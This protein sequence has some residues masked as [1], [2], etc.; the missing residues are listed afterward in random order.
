MSF[1]SAVLLILAAIG[2]FLSVYFLAARGLWQRAQHSQSGIDSA[3]RTIASLH[4]VEAAF[5][6]HEAALRGCLLMRSTTCEQDLSTAATRIGGELSGLRALM[7]DG[8]A[9]AEIDRLDTLARS[10]AA[11]AIGAT[12]PFGG[13]AGTPALSEA[14]VLRI[15]SEIRA[16]VMRIDAMAG[17]ILSDRKVLYN[18]RI[19]ACYLFSVGAFAALCLMVGLMLYRIYQV[20][21]RNTTVEDI[22]R[23]SEARYRMLVEGSDMVLIV[24][25]RAG[26]VTFASDNIERLTGYGC[27]ELVG[28]NALR[29]MPKLAGELPADTPP[30]GRD[31]EYLFTTRDGKERWAAY[32]VTEQTGP[33]GH[34]EYHIIAWDID[35]EKR[36]RLAM[37]GLEEARRQ[38]Q[39]LL[40]DVIDH[41]PNMVY[42]KDLQGNYAVVNRPLRELFGKLTPQ[43]IGRKLGEFFGPEAEDGR[44]RRTDEHVVNDKQPV[45]FEEEYEFYGE[46]RYFWEVKFPVFDEG[47]AVRYVGGIASDITERKQEEL[48]LREA[49]GE[50]EKARTA[51]EAF[52][53]SMSHEIRT[54]MNGVVGMANLMLGTRLSG[55]QREFTETILE[56]ARNLLALIN[57][58]LDFSK[59]ESGR[60]EFEHTPFRVRHAL[61]RAIHPLR[62]KAEEKGLHLDLELVE[63]LPEVLIGDALRLQQ[64]VI[65]LVG[66]AIKFTSEGAVTVR[67]GGALAGTGAVMLR[68]DVQDTGIGIPKDKLGFV[69]ESFAQQHAAMS[70]SYGGTGLGLAIVRQLAE[71]Q[72][73]TVEVESVLGKGSTF[74]VSIPF[75]VSTE[76]AALP[77]QES[78]VSSTAPEH[79]LEGLCIL[80]AED[81]P[82][83]QKVV[84]NTLAR[85]GAEV[86]I[87]GSGTQAVSALRQQSFDVVLM[88]I[89][90]P[91]MDGYAATRAIREELNSGIPIIA[92][93]ADALK[94]E[95]ERCIAAGMTDFIS[96]PF[97]PAELYTKILAAAAVPAALKRPPLI[98]ANGAAT[99]APPAD[100]LVDLSYLTELSGDDPAYLREV[101]GIFLGSTPEAIG[102]L[103]T[104]VRS[105]QPDRDAVR[106]TAHGLK[107]SFGVVRVQGIL[108]ALTEVEQGAAILPATELRETVARIEQTF[109]QAR[110]ELERIAAED[111]APQERT[112]A[113]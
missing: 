16:S 104:L 93:T 39:Q 41:V 99:D 13:T 71:L 20:V 105:E 3:Q 110:A 47:G 30:E 59:I 77:L 42:L 58:L 83:N 29:I 56:S 21:R 55:E 108:E 24:G 91:E 74:S 57:D 86:V 50:A 19:S 101:V 113:T 73:G 63:D 68:I 31:R 111:A 102:R 98:S 26:E 33:E 78:P 44:M 48:A 97:D 85:Q 87:T 40:Q 67:A 36:M 34:P 109:G 92:M 23:T 7:T 37:K 89:Q 64:I 43:V 8:D 70:R 81:N 75:E 15:N 2:L 112:P 9:L 45:A 79:I 82:I 14:A 11:L 103:G 4:L 80:V 65:N 32:R 88:D 46:K 12:Q 38:Q 76:E 69:F 53:A 6:N 17:S 61:R 94:G 90:M 49:K 66:N 84:R 22:A 107:S 100:N 35:R 27:D 60:F 72:G 51:Q 1:R 18:K 10:K 5:N 96:K 54:P 106:K 25:N 52:L 95:R 28:R 62:F